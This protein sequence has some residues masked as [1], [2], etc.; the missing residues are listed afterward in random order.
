MK[1]HLLTLLLFSLALTACSSQRAS[2][3]LIGAW[4][5]I[6]YGTA[7]SLTSAVAD[8]EAGITFSEDGTMSGTSACNEYGGA[9]SVEGDQ[10]TFS[11]IVSTRKF[12]ELLMEQERTMYQ[13]LTGTA[14]YQLQGN[15]L[16]LINNGRTLVFATPSYP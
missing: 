13:V 3:S 1:R 7:D 2:T 8:T 14:A 9:Y 4:K 6:S 11:E 12:C 15:T 10:V 16:T 5:L